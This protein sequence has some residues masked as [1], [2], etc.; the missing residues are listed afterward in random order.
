MLLSDCRCCGENGGDSWIA[1]RFV[2]SF[3]DTAVALM[4][5]LEEVLESKNKR[6]QATA[7]RM[8]LGYHKKTPP[9]CNNL[10]AMPFVMYHAQ[11]HSHL[12]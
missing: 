8:L 3:T 5:L 6:F 1:G 4:T 7:K 10:S 12:Y 9:L 2:F 11:S